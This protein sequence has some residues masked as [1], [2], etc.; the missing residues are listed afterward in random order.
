[1]NIQSTRS[2]SQS[3]ATRRLGYYAIGALLALAACGGT[4]NNNGDD[5]G[6]D[7]PTPLPDDGPCAP[8]A[9]RCNGDTAQQCNEAGDHW[10]TIEECE[11]FCQDGVCALDGLEVASDMQLDGNILVAGAVTVRA[12]ATLSSPT[13]NLTI[14]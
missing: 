9:L 3:A 2:R 1:M 8:G 10:D 14:T 6:P 11:T 13:G 7:D 5:D 12:G 4:N